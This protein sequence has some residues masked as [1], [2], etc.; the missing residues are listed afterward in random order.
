MR[1]RLLAHLQTRKRQASAKPGQ[2]MIEMAL[3]AL[4]LLILTFGTVDAGIYMYRYVQA[5]NCTREAARRAAVR[6]DP[7]NIP[8]CVDASLAPNV[9]PNPGG[10]PGT[11]VTATVSITHSWIAIGHLI[12]GIGS[13]IQIN[14]ST[15]MRME[16]Q[17]V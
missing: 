6:Q 16:G 3:V 13:T 12:P 5:A 8:Y 9:S 17:K 4:I 15:T 7:S 1:R 14:S 10:A 11:D 2:A